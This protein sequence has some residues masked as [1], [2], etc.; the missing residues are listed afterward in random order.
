[1]RSESATT[2]LFVSTKPSGVKTKP[3]PLPE[4]RRRWDLA[5]STSTFTTDGLS[6]SATHV[7]V[8]EYA[9][10]ASASASLVST[11]IFFCL[12]AR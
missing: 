10:R 8:F 4:S 9:S 6:S 11:L 2:W 7:T 5:F 3:E 12:I 1:M